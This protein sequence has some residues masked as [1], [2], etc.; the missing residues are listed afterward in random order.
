[1]KFRINLTIFLKKN[2]ANDFNILL[3]KDREIKLQKKF[4]TIVIKER[5]IWTW[6][7]FCLN[8]SVPFKSQVTFSN[9]YKVKIQLTLLV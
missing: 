9:K 6:Y 2:K 4:N 5:R 1:M 8:W 7:L 3:I